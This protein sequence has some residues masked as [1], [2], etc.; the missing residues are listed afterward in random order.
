[1]NK[2][3]ITRYSNKVSK[4]H[5]AD[6]FEILDDAYNENHRFYHNWHHISDMLEKL[7]QL[8]YLVSNIEQITMAIFWHDV[9]YYTKDIDGNVI[10]DVVNV[11]ASTN[12]F[13]ENFNIDKYSNYAPAISMVLGTAKHTIAIPS[14][15]Y[16]EGFEQDFKLFLD[17][18][19]SGFGSSYDTFI[20]N[21]NNIRKEFAF[22][23][24]EDFEFGRRAAL[25]N[26]W[27]AD[28]LFKLPET[29]ELWEKKAKDNLT[30]WFE[31]E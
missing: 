15:H 19:L 24:D 27:N 10:P 14:F 2:E 11:H 6:A 16:Y 26:F 3:N 12:K 23:P 22:V 1:M 28:P 31:K 18:D 4:F 7:D 5:N 8:S 29:Q 21:G 13:M 25:L 17:L 20:K 30:K 9:V